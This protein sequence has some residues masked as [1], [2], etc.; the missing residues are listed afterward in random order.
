MIMLE[1]QIFLD[2]LSIN[3][4]LTSESEYDERIRLN[5]KSRNVSSTIFWE[6][7]YAQYFLTILTYMIDFIL[8]NCIVALFHK[9]S[10]F[11]HPQMQ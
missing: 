11:S 7:S 3:I 2:L 5:E 4:I 6:F 8:M 9:M 10:T 1:K